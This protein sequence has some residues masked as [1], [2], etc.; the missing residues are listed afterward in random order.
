[1]YVI[2]LY[3]IYCMKPSMNTSL[4]TDVLGGTSHAEEL[5]KSSN[6]IFSNSAMKL[7]NSSLLLLAGVHSSFICLLS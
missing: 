6:M 1:M 5:S 2:Y 3:I 4:I 7:L